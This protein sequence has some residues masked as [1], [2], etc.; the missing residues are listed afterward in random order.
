MTGDFALTLPV[1]LAVAI[2]STISRAISYGTIYTTK[3]L[4]RGTDID[5]TTL[6]R[7]LQDLKIADAM[8]PF[9][10]PQRAAMQHCR[11]RRPGARL[12]PPGR[13]RLAGPVIYQQDPQSVFATE[14]RPRN[15][16]CRASHVGERVRV[17]VG[18]TVAGV[19]ARIAARCR[20]HR[21]ESYMPLMPDQAAGEITAEVKAG[22]LDG[23][24]AAAVLTAAGHRGPGRRTWPDNLTAR[25]AKVLA[26]LARGYP[27]RHVATRL[28]VTF[29]TVANHVEHLY[30]K[31]GVS[32]RA[33]ATLYAMQHGLV[34]AFEPPAD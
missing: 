29:K 27:N 34:G 26:L 6:W 25:E 9:R 19:K 17:S 30:T 13:A 11:R 3:L 31:I 23:S 8:R 20:G 15:R 12:G 5:R 32:S 24:V 18:R 14:S 28:S 16:A 2:A 1:M 33:A 22:R 21:A 10:P 7:A 4:R